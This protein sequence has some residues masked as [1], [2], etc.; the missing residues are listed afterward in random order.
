M[1][2]LSAGDAWSIER[3]LRQFGVDPKKP[4]AHYTPP[5]N[6]KPMLLFAGVIVF[7]VVSALFGVLTAR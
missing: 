5:K 3:L 7:L 2:L 6:R 4:G 1:H